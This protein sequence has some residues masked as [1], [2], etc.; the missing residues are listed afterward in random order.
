MSTDCATPKGQVAIGHER[1]LAHQMAA[2]WNADVFFTGVGVETDTAVVDAAF[3]R[4]GVLMAVAEIKW[5]GESLTLDTL[6]NLDSY[7]IKHRKLQRGLVVA[8]LLHAPLVLIVGLADCTV[9]WKVA[10]ADG[11]WCEHPHV[12]RTRT[13][14]SINGGTALRWNAYVSLSRMHVEVE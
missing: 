10:E 9:W 12:A 5:R 8:R 11:S 4:H 2:R 6:R 13:Q 7:L 1:R 3:S 14:R